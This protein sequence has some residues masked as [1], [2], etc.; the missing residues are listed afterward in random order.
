MLCS[1]RAAIRAGIF[2]FA[3]ALAKEAIC[4]A[5][6]W[7]SQKRFQH[8]LS[9]HPEHV[10]KHVAQFHVAVLQHLAH[11]VFLRAGSLNQFAATPRQ[12]PQ[13][14]L[15]ARRNKTRRHHRV[16]QQMGQPPGILVVGFMPFAR[17]HFLRIGQSHPHMAF[18]HIEHRLP[19]PARALHDHV[20]ASLA[21]DPRARL[22]QLAHRG[23]EVADFEPGF[24]IGRSG[25]HAH[26]D[27]LLTHVHAGASLQYCGYHGLLPFRHEERA[28][29]LC[30]DLLTRAYAPFGDSCTRIQPVS[31]ASSHQY[32]SRPISSWQ[33]H[34]RA[35]FI[36]VG[37]RPPV[38]RCFEFTIEQ[39]ELRA[40]EIQ[41][42]LFDDY[43]AEQAT[44]QSPSEPRPSG[45]GRTADFS[46]AGS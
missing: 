5:S 28:P 10:G 11:P 46:P 38:I 17:L 30:G 34:C 9:G 4:A 39:I 12:V 24:P 1:S 45:S 43:W 21:S 8:Q 18:Q 7:P 44:A 13:L 2:F 22:F 42:D 20:R 41:P 35:I 31:N 29:R 33:L 19:V 36:P 32:P 6:A 15:R 26:G 3:W 23:P 25:H 14:A 37:D 40:L 27:E 16:A